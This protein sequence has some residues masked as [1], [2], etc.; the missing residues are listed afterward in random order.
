VTIEK[1]STVLE[2]LRE[3]RCATIYQ[4][5]HKITGKMLYA[6]FTETKYDDMHTS[7]PMVSDPVYVLVVGGV[8]I[9]PRGREFLGGRFEQP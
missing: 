8:P 2:M 9:G 7:P 3:H 4:Y 6:F 5:R 1:A